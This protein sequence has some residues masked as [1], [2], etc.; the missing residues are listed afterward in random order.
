MSAEFTATVAGSTVAAMTRPFLRNQPCSISRFSGWTPMPMLWFT[1]KLSADGTFS[2]GPSIEASASIRIEDVSATPACLAPKNWQHAAA[3][4][5]FQSQADI[6][7]DGSG[8]CKED[9]PTSA[10]HVDILNEVLR[11]DAGPIATISSAQVQNYFP[12]GLHNRHNEIEW[13]CLCFSRVALSFTY[14]ACFVVSNATTCRLLAS[15]THGCPS[16]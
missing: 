5:P 1:A 6:G 4:G 8:N 10:P 14:A 15:R 13:C 2:V 12:Q 11:F 7:E 3:A 9:M 16:V